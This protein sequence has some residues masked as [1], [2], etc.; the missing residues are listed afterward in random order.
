MS[1]NSAKSVDISAASTRGKSVPRSRPTTIQQ[2]PMSTITDVQI[3]HYLGHHISAAGSRTHREPRH[4]SR[5]RAGDPAT[6]HEDY[7][8][9]SDNISASTI[10]AELTASFVCQVARLSIKGN[11][12]PSV[13]DWK[14]HLKTRLAVLGLPVSLLDEQ[15]GMPETPQ[16]PLRAKI[17]SRG[18]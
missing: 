12:G 17:F 14:A 15:L 8:P 10:A 2:Q 11:H 16:Q 4:N 18:L 1:L 3:F 9:V 5:L 6:L 7:G 13:L